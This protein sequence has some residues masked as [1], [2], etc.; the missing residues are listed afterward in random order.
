ML[1][2]YW[3]RLELASISKFGYNIGYAAGTK[4]KTFS[5]S[6]RKKT[7]T[8]KNDSANGNSMFKLRE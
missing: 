7:S 8:Y 6:A 3:T 4:E 1:I 2:L 5:C